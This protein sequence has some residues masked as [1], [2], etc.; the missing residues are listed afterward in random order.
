MGLV[1]LDFGCDGETYGCS[2][3]RLGCLCEC[4]CAGHFRCGQSPIEV[5][6]FSMV[7]E[8]SEKTH[9]AAIL[10]TPHNTIRI[11]DKPDLVPQAI[12]K[13]GTI[14]VIVVPI[15]RRLADVKDLDDGSPSAW[16][17][18]RHIQVGVAANLQEHKIGVLLD[19]H[20]CPGRVDTRRH[21]ANHGL[22][23]A[24]LHGG[25]IIVPAVHGGLRRSVELLP[26]G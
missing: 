2:I 24:G 6:C 14:G 15:G 18:R 23:V 13:H 9:I 7:I 10:N 12:S 21:T 3:F 20:D 16:L 1:M 4:P 8:R 17:Q 11:L 5:R 19:H 25:G 22:L 26:V